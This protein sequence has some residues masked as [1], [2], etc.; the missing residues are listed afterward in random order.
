M[1]RSHDPLRLD[2]KDAD[3]AREMAARLTGFLEANPQPRSVLRLETEDTAIPLEVTADIVELLARVLQRVGE[4]GAVAF[5]SEQEELTTQQAADALNVSRPYLVNN[6]LERGLLPYRRVGNRRRIR[7]RD[8]AD[9]QARDAQQRARA[10]EELT[11]EAEDL[12][13]YEA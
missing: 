5:L 1:T 10:L 2:T 12:G 3:L 8:L 11:R 6:L 7:A 4:G 9:Y 13:L